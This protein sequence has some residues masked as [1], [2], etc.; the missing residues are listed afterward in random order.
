M[1]NNSQP[2]ICIRIFKNQ[3]EKQTEMFPHLDEQR[4]Q[5]CREICY[6][7][8]Y[9]SPVV[10]SLFKP[11]WRTIEQID[12]SEIGNEMLRLQPFFKEYVNSLDIWAKF[13][14]ASG[15]SNTVPWRLFSREQ[16]LGK[17]IDLGPRGLAALSPRALSLVTGRGSQPPTG[18]SA[19]VV[20]LR[21]K[22][23]SLF[24]RFF[25]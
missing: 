9:T 16:K 12:R 25:F 17:V 1:H 20:S 21:F 10:N 23:S 3:L 15:R 14:K 2:R 11:L 13:Q 6:L 22:H 8:E 5:S 4:V 19:F 18:V 24:R 7:H